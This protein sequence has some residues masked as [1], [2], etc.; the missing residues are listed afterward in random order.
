VYKCNNKDFIDRCIQAYNDDT[1]ELS[2]KR[3]EIAKENSWRN[4]VEKV[5]EIFYGSKPLTTDL[6]TIQENVA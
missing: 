1:H 4:R 5:K 6:F 2:L 3:I